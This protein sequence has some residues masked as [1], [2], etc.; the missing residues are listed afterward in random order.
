M[1]KKKSQIEPVM[2]SG[3]AND[4]LFKRFAFQ[5]RVLLC[6]YGGDGYHI[7]TSLLIAAATPGLKRQKNKTNCTRCKT[8]S[9]KQVNAPFS[10]H[11]RLIAI[12]V[13]RRQL[14]FHQHVLRQQH[15]LCVP[16]YRHLPSSFTCHAR[17]GNDCIGNF[18]DSVQNF[19][20]GEKC[21]NSTVKNTV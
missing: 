16:S 8:G 9:S 18:R 19:S 14:P 4:L 6:T 21:M 3:V 12:H 7:A 5:R 11:S 1:K 17:T 10:I 15:H 2:N 20:C 13:P